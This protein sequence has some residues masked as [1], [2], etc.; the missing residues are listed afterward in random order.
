MDYKFKGVCPVVNVPFLVNGDIDYKGLE[1]EIDYVLDAGCTSLCLF[2]FNSEPHKMSITEKKAT[3]E[4][5]LKYVGGRA[6][7]LIGIIENSIR[8]GIELAQ[9]AEA[10][11][12]DGLILYPPSL[13]TPAGDELI[14]YFEAISQ[15][16]NLEIMIQ[17]NPRS[18]G[19]NMSQEFILDAFEKVKGFRYLKVECPIPMRKLRK[20]VSA[21]EGKLKCYSGNGGIFAIDAIL[22]GAWGIM[23]GAMTAG[24]FVA[25]YAL[26]EQGKLDAARD[27][28][29]YMLPLVWYEDQSLEFY[30]SCEKLLLHRA[31]VF[32]SATVRKPECALTDAEK[33]E[34]FTLYDRAKAQIDAVLK[35]EGMA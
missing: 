20:M 25:M 10:C 27:I 34:L 30:V 23:P 3:V 13:S 12:A 2:A 1:R 5:F 18:T 35:A 14:G 24:Y 16:V 11:G 6:E 31:G 32:E 29:Q 33:Q 4:A 22:N 15:S 17:D 9:Q 8:G 19:V 26:A 7:T 21:T 28:F